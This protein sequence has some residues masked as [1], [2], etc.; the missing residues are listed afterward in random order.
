MTAFTPDLS[1]GAERFDVCLIDA[2]DPRRPSA[3]A[4]ALSGS[5]AVTPEVTRQCEALTAAAVRQGLN[6]DLLA[7]ACVGGRV[8]AA[9]LAITSPGRSSMVQVTLPV[10]D[11]PAH[12]ASRAVLRRLREA[13]SAR[14]V[15]LLQA[16]VQPEDGELADVYRSVGFR[17]LTELLYMD[18]AVGRER[19]RAEGPPGVAVRTYSADDHALFVRGLEAT[20]VDSFDCPGL[21]G[22]RATEDVLAGH[23]ATG[24]YDPNGWYVALCDNMPVGVL[25]TASLPQRSALEVVYVGVAHSHRGQGVGNYLMQLAAERARALGLSTVTLGVD[26]TNEPARRMYARWGYRAMHRRRVW[27]AALPEQFRA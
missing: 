21:T 20:Y 6:L 11:A 14:G 25:L 12:A 2:D 23:R 17:Y 19:S 24:V 5:G 7:A 10:E 1:L 9:A 18:C 13:A 22:L 16:L 27:I 3:L 15:V 26:A 4:H 8:L